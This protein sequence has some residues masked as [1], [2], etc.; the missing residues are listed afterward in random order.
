MDGSGQHD[1]WDAFYAGRA[2]SDVPEEPSSFADWVRGRI[3]PDDA[4]VELGFG[5]ARDALWF[6]RLGHPVRGY[7]FAESAVRRADD[8]VRAEGLSAQFGVLDL[9]DAQAVAG[10][11][12]ELS[13]AEGRQVVYGRFLVHSLETAGRHHLLDLARD[14]LT[15]D[16]RGELYLE[17]RTGKDQGAA[18]LF[19]DEHFRVYLDPQV[20]VDDVEARGGQ[21]VE[22]EQ[23]HGL[24]VYKSEDPHVARLVASW[25]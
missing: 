19:G 1:Y 14:A 9:Y 17:F 23:G 7:D 18:H 21:V 12:A 10:V 20:V 11:G 8:R 4:V 24:A 3:R 2:S 15:G 6:A 13:R 5:T 16:S 25:A 22:L